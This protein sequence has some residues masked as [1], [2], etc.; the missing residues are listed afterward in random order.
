MLTVGPLAALVVLSAA[1]AYGAWRFWCAHALTGCR[2]ALVA[3]GVSLFAPVSALGILS[4]NQTRTHAEA[5]LP[6]VG[7]VAAAGFALSRTRRLAPMKHGQWR[8]GQPEPLATLLETV[9]GAPAAAHASRTAAL[10]ESLAEPLSVSPADADDVVLAALLHALGTPLGPPVVESC[11]PDAA[12]RAVA[13][14]I[15][16]RIPRCHGVAAAIAAAGERWDGGGPLGL[17]GEDPPIAARVIA[18][19]DAFDRASEAGLAAARREIREGSGT[20][21]DPVVVS[22]LLHI[23]RERPAAGAA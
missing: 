19:A 14:N 8:H 3:S 9:L 13:A 15:L 17:S 21:Y 22:E 11:P 18:V 23:F 1:A 20:R 7:A 4:F 5:S 6:A 16:R 12:A 2:L 10:A